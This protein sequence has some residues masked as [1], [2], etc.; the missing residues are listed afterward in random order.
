M[1]LHEQS[2]NK[3]ATKNMFNISV[4]SV[5]TRKELTIALMCYLSEKKA[6]KARKRHFSQAAVFFDSFLV[7][8]TKLIRK[9][10]DEEKERSGEI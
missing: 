3:P 5:T 8:Q 2:D 10:R 6:T 4:L 1:L 7:I 9:K